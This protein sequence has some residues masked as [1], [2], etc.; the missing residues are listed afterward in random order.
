MSR[1][2]ASLALAGILSATAL[3]SGCSST[4]KDHTSGLPDDTK[5]QV[6][7]M[8]AGV[9]CQ[10]LPELARAIDST[11][12]GGQALSSADR[13]VWTEAAKALIQRQQGC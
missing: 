9:D 5:Q 6:Q 4:S 13:A 12:H 10:R 3:A 7:L 1:R 11:L 8:L 2:L